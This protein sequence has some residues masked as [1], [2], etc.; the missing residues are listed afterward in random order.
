MKQPLQHQLAEI[1]EKANRLHGITFSGPVRV[2]IGELREA[3]SA[4]NSALNDSGDINQAECC[5]LLNRAFQ[6]SVFLNNCGTGMEMGEKHWF[7]SMAQP[8]VMNH[9][10]RWVAYFNGLAGALRSGHADSWL[11]KNPTPPGQPGQ[12]ERPGATMSHERHYTK[13][14][15]VES[16]IDF[17]VDLPSEI[18]LADLE[19]CGELTKYPHVSSSLGQRGEEAGEPEQPSILFRSAGGRQ[20]FQVHLQGL[21]FNWLPP[22]GPW[23]EMRDE[24]RRIWDRYRRVARPTK[25]KRVAVRG[26]Y[27]LDF[28]LP[29]PSMK[30]Y[31]RTFPE[32]RTALPQALNGFFMRLHIPHADI[33]G[34]LLLS[35]TVIDPDH[36]DNRCTIVLDIDMFRQANLPQA[37]SEVWAVAEALNERKARDV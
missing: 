19:Q 7:H 1:L 11:A 35:E 16:I 15:L 36:Q 12:S 37:D 24:A 17:Q 4:L 25:V 10:G 14:P 6:L 34:A 31:L 13:D 30:D 27:R 26:I 28:P 21:T 9:L 2:R 5:E 20:M 18:I 23:E 33:Q 8:V 32:I 22:S 29:L 3:A